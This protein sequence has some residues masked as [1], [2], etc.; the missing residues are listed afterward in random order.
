MGIG[1]TPEMF[2]RAL[3]EPQYGGS[4]DQKA[5]GT[6]TGMQA[7]ATRLDS[8]PYLLVSPINGPLTNVADHSEPGSHDTI[9]RSL[10]GTRITPRR[11]WENVRGT[12]A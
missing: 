7:P 9:T 5:S 4:L 6:V 8:C 2:R 10:R 3:L 12:S 1:R 11:F